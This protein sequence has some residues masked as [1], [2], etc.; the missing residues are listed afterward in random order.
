MKK[1]SGKMSMLNIKLTFINFR[2]NSRVFARISQNV[3]L[4]L[5]SCKI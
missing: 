5:H 1:E 4:W 2:E 3:D